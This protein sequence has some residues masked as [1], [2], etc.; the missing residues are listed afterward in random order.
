MTSSRTP[1]IAWAISRFW[2]PWSD[3]TLTKWDRA[4]MAHSLEVRV[5]FLDHRVVELAWRLRPA[6]K[7]GQAGWGSK[8][9][10][11]RILYRYVPPELVDRPKKG[12]SSPL[13][14]WL[15]GPSRPWAEDLLDER[16]LRD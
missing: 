7:Y 5:P 1:S 14:V 4:G 6:L 3:G 10:L 13:P 9:L 11:R 2:A 12:F 15:R 8:R 16:K